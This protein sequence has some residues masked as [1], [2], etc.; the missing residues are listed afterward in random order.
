ML[1]HENRSL[2][3]AGREISLCSLKREVL[4]MLKRGGCFANM[5]PEHVFTSKEEAIQSI[6][7]RLDPERCA[8]CTARVFAE[9][10]ERPGGEDNILN[11]ESV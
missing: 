11:S 5:G 6:V 9:C 4:D 2:R 3:L 8:G 7:S 1:F 10:S